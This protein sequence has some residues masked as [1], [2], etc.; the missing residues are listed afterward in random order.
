MRFL[1]A[2]HTLPL[3][4]QE[5]HRVVKLTSKLSLSNG[6]SNVSGMEISFKITL[7]GSN[8]RAN[9]T[10]GSSRGKSRSISCWISGRQSPPKSEVWPYLFLWVDECLLVR[11][12]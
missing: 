11:C 12:P 3:N 2:M 7:K 8:Q 9:M 1:M 4:G 6:P 10:Y 5:I